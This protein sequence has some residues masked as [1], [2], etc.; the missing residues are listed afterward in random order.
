MTWWEITGA[1]TFYASGWLVFA[2]LFAGHFGWKAAERR[3]LRSYA[4]AT[5]PYDFGWYLVGG[6]AIGWLW[7]IFLAGRCIRMERFAVG[8]EREAIVRQQ[9]ERIKELEREMGVR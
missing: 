5:E 7:P 9:R 3:T 1:A 4:S 2:R 8:A 6:L